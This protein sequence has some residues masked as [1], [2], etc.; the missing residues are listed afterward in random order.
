MVIGNGRFSR[1]AD[2]ALY[3]TEVDGTLAGGEQSLPGFFQTICPWDGPFQS[4]RSLRPIYAV[5]G[6]ARGIMDVAFDGLIF[7]YLFYF[8]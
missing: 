5:D 6:V 1:K 3:E 7:F 8:M 2:P 4:D